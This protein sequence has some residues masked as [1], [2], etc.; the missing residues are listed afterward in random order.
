MPSTT[1]IIIDFVTG[2]SWEVPVHLYEK[3]V[4]E[5]PHLHEDGKTVVQQWLDSLSQEEKEKV[6]KQ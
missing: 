6:Q 4:S 2:E 3:F 1:R 5:S